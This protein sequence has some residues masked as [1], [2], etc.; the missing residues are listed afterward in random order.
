MPALLGPGQPRAIWTSFCASVL[1]RLAGP[2]WRTW[3][4]PEA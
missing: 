4:N 3:R 2:Y 1:P